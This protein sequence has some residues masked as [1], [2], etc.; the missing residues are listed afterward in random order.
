MCALRAQLQHYIAPMSYESKKKEKL[1]LLLS[2][3]G[4]T[5]CFIFE[6]KKIVENLVL[7]K[8]SRSNF[9]QHPL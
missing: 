6:K 4:Y 5:L 2:L 8:L 7:F 3:F 1:Q 9:I